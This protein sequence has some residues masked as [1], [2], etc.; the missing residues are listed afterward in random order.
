MTSACT[1][2]HVCSKH[3]IDPLSHLFAWC[4]CLWPFNVVQ[5]ESIQNAF[6]HGIA[7][8]PRYL[9][10]ALQKAYASIS[11]P[12]FR[13]S[14]IRSAMI[15]AWEAAV[16]L[17]LARGRSCEAALIHQRSVLRVAKQLPTDMGARLMRNERNL[18]GSNY[19]CG[20]LADDAAIRDHPDPEVALL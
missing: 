3:Q 20:R 2:M 4:S 7:G 14:L 15:D 12:F 17:F 9:S 6:A 11:S 1:F 5:S 18:D 10:A 13:H 8:M 16:V 19:Y